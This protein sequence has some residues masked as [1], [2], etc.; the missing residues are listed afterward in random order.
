MRGLLRAR[1]RRRPARVSRNRR[2]NRHASSGAPR[3]F[4]P[5]GASRVTIK[6]L[7]EGLN[8]FLTPN[9][10]V[11]ADVGDA[12]FGPAGLFIHHPTEFLGPAYYASLRFSVPARLGAHPA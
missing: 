1:W 11:V 10:V 5:R 9:T 12:L 4:T 7:F 3:K 2:P 8:S 6:R